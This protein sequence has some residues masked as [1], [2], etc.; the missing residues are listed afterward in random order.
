MGCVLD[1][2]II[3]GIFEEELHGVH[4]LSGSPLD[5]LRRI[6]GSGIRLCIDDK[7]IMESEW[8]SCVDPDWF[9]NWFLSLTSHTNVVA[10]RPARCLQ[11]LK[12]LRVEFGFPRSRDCT[13][14][15]VAITDA[16]Q[17]G[18]SRLLS[19][20][21]DF[22]DPRAKAQAKVRAKLMDGRAVGAV[23]RYLRKTHAVHVQSVILFR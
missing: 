17:E 21:V 15:A 2:N 13:V 12:R 18:T 7:A 10:I 11:T 23:A 9:E 4:T 20:D 22:F 8:V 16:E 3:K 6:Q 5:L 1:A 19:E 14:L